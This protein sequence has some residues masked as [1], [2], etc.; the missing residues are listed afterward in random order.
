[1]KTLAETDPRNRGAIAHKNPNVDSDYI[2]QRQIRALFAKVTRKLLII[3]RLIR[4]YPRKN[5]NAVHPD[6]ESY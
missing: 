5:P 3:K 2:P 1:M 4:R 6:E